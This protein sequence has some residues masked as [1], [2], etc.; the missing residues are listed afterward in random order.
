MYEYDLQSETLDNIKFQ[1]YYE[2][3]LISDIQR[4]I[5]SADFYSNATG[6]LLVNKFETRLP[7]NTI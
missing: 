4:L 1:M 3:L 5:M 6:T 7:N 2:I